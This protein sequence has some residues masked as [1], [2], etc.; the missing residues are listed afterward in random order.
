MMKLQARL[1]SYLICLVLLLGMMP[2]LPAG[3]TA[4]EDNSAALGTQLEYSGIGQ[5]D[6]LRSSGISVVNTD[7]AAENTAKQYIVR[8][9]EPEQ[10]VL[11]MLEEDRLR[12][13]YDVVSEELLAE[14]L[15]EGCVEWYEE[16]YSVELF[17]PAS[18]EAITVSDNEFEPKYD[19]SRWDLEMVHAQFGYTLNCTGQ[20]VKIGVIDSGIAAHDDLSGNLLPG[21]NYIDNTTDTNDTYGHGTFIGGIIASVDDGQG[22]IGL[23][24]EAKLVPL[25]CFDDKTT[26]VSLICKAI[27]GAVD[28]FNCDVI[29]MSF[30]LNQESRMLKEAIDYAAAKGVIVTAAV[31]NRGETGLYYPAAY[32]NVIGVGSV[33]EDGSVSTTSQHNESVFVTAPGAALKSTS[34]AGGYISGSGTSYATPFVTAAVAV[35]LSVDKEIDL[36]RVKDILSA[37]AEDR[38]EEGYD[39]YYGYGILNVE[40]CLKT[41]LDGTEY[42]I[43]PVETG[44]EEASAVV[45]NNTGEVLNGLI[46]A[47]EYSGRVMNGLKTS[48]LTIPEGKTVTVKNSLSE[49]S[50]RL[51]VW[52]SM[53][54]NTIV[55]NA[56]IIGGA[57]QE[58]SGSEELLLFSVDLPESEGKYFSLLVRD[59]ENKVV[60]AVQDKRPESGVYDILVPMES[61]TEMPEWATTCERV[62]PAMI[63]GTEGSISTLRHTFETVTIPPQKAENGY[64]EHICTICGYTYQDDQTQA[65]GYFVTYDANGGEEAPQ[66]QNKRPEEALFLS[67]D[68]PVREGYTFAGWSTDR[69]AESPEY[70][71]GGEY[72]ADE[73]ITLYALWRANTYR[74]IYQVDGAEYKTVEA[75]C[76]ESI[77]P[78]NDPVKPGYTFSGWNGI[79]E[80]MPASDVTVS[81]TFAKE[82]SS[83]GGNGGGGSSSGSSGVGS[84][85]G[86]SSSGGTSEPPASEEEQNEPETEENVDESQT[87][88]IAELI[89]FSDVNE[90]D[91]FYESIRFVVKN[92]LMNGIS[93]T[94]FAPRAKLTRAMFVT[95]LHRMAQ[96][97]DTAGGIY[98]SDVSEQTYYAEAVRW[99]AAEKIVQGVSETEFAPEREITREQMAVMAYRYAVYKGYPISMPDEI[100]YSDYSDI[101]AFALDAVEWAYGEKILLGNDKGAFCPVDTATRAEA[102]AMF[103]RLYERIQ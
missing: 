89:P 43:S 79:P 30:G 96:E 85:S 49:N 54:D 55:S 74:L 26:E 38:G 94:E 66:A 72:L 47:G 9:R 100:G 57:G 52:N 59:A 46:V 87:D 77:I 11:F 37:S 71:P 3:A 80:T 78:E 25:K 60:Y 62:L 27:Y 32:D 33:N 24:P 51:F 82:Q 45:Y 99:A 42:F 10:P 29:N 64:T 41:M 102:A 63:D 23:A 22:I 84:S 92:E 36:A 91:W 67:D 58:E 70:A 97:P 4:A 34:T 5:D 1:L 14:L 56:R 65:I 18:D 31:G 50:A 76:G 83:S 101:S 69:E 7:S 98:F 2:V 17:E 21:Y 28:D 81:G 68:I 13:S 75:K 15:E 8:Y 61:V 103:M 73:D 95:V 53:E 86:G 48:A 44:G 90:E 20:S 19:E 6:N 88:D 12:P 39:T 40:N 35:M 93:E 16:D